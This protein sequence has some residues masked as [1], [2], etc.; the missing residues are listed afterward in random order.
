VANKNEPTPPLKKDVKF[1]I[2][3]DPQLA[4]DAAA[5]AASLGGLSAV[6]R[7]LLRRWLESG[8]EIPD[9]EV[10]RELVSAPARRQLPKPAERKPRK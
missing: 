10:L 8:D 2:R 6:I 9:D 5:R 4:E 1:Q 7:V 3:L